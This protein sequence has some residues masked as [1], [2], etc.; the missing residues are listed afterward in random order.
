MGFS[1][2]NV[3]FESSKLLITVMRLRGFTAA[4]SSSTAMNPTNSLPKPHYSARL[5]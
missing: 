5:G 4:T 3:I 2:L 1:T